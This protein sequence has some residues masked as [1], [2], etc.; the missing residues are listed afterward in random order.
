GR[1]RYRVRKHT[2][3][4]VFGIIKD[5]LGFRRFTLRGLANVTAEWQLLIG[6]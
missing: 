3:E 6:T 2:V 5:A 1:R 4:P